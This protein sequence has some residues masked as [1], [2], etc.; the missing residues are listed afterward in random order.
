MPRTLAHSPNL[1]RQISTFTMSFNT[2]VP[3]R[4]HHLHIHQTI[5]SQIA[6]Q[7]F[8]PATNARHVL[9][10]AAVVVIHLILSPFAPLSAQSLVTSLSSLK[11]C[12]A[13]SPASLTAPLPHL[14]VNTFHR[15]SVFTL[16]TR[17]LTDPVHPTCTS[18]FETWRTFLLTLQFH[19]CQVP[20]TIV[21]SPLLWF[22]SASASRRVT[23][24]PEPPP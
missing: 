5:H 23:L 7:P 24:F 17:F 15:L 13:N 8:M 1:L 3:C 10:G 18:G 20:R 21:P 22:L 4:K 12:L 19:R 2:E 14:C 16:L 11:M 9:T 6:S